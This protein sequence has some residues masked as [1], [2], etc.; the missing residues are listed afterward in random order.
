VRFRYKHEI[1]PGAV[2]QVWLVAEEVEEVSPELVVPDAEGKPYTVHYDQAQFSIHF[3]AFRK[4][5]A[6]AL[7]S[8]YLLYFGV[9]EAASF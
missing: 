8:A 2:A 5:G 3:D 1:D 4:V 9:G 7:V 6:A